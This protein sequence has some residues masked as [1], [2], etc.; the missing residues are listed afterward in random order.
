MDTLQEVSFPKWT[1]IESKGETPLKVSGLA[2]ITGVPNRNNRIYP[3]AVMQREVARMNEDLAHSNR[4]GL[5]NHPSHGE[6][7]LSDMGLKF[8][9]LW[10]ENENV[11][12]EAEIIPTQR[13]K[14]LEAIIKAGI[15]VGI[16]SRAYATVKPTTVEGTTYSLVQEDMELISFDA[17]IDPSVSSAAILR[18]EGKSEA[19]PTYINEALERLLVPVSIV[20]LEKD[21]TGDTMNT[22]QLI[23]L[24][25][26][27]GAIPETVDEAVVV[28][29]TDIPVVEVPIVEGT[30]PVVETPV[31]STDIPALVAAVPTTVVEGTEATVGEDA[32]IVESTSEATTESTPPAEVTPVVTERVVESPEL[33]ERVIAAETRTKQLEEGTAVL[34]EDQNIQMAIM[35]LVMAMKAELDEGDFDSVGAL[36]DCA[37][38]L[39]FT[40]MIDD[41]REGDGSAQESYKALATERGFTAAQTILA[42]LATVVKRVQRDNKAFEMTKDELYGRRMLNIFMETADTAQVVEDTFDMVKA[43]VVMEATGKH[44]VPEI[45]GQILTGREDEQPKLTEEQLEMRRLAFGPNR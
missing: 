32:P 3:T 36:A 25:E 5:V 44:A 16:S 2:S 41:M 7:S 1:V 26:A 20:E 19:V 43:R 10:C 21:H 23:K 29:T 22:E 31:V 38:H 45:R 8:T 18:Y 12:F 34:Q 11:F 6:S 35:A 24:V 14:D 4:V 27:Q 37:S 30:A 15:N 40:N 17:V 9:K 39:T 33:I 13:G 42:P 28:G